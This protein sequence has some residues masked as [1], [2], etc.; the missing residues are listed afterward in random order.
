[1]D[2]TSKIKN[3]HSDQEM[4]MENQKQDRVQSTQQMTKLVDLLKDQSYMEAYKK[5]EDIEKRAIKNGLY[6][7]N[8]TEE[9]G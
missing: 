8:L 3:T 2:N 9:N 4:T 7:N 5:M 6:D 1:M